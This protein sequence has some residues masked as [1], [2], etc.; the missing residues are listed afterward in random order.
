M[1]K[2][3]I[4]VMTSREQNRTAA[5]TKD[6][7]EEKP[8]DIVDLDTYVPIPAQPV[9][10]DGGST[11]SNTKRSKNSQGNKGQV[12]GKQQSGEIEQVNNLMSKG[13]C[14]CERVPRED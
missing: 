5:L 11:R 13:V 10:K 4:K 9:A 8:T 2:L 12:N 6:Q 3:K 1:L 7:K 14:L